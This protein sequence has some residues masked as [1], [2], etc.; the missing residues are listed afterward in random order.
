MQSFCNIV[1]VFTFT[2]LSL[3]INASLLDKSIH[4]FKDFWMVVYSFWQ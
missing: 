4:L 2:V 3:L 1:N